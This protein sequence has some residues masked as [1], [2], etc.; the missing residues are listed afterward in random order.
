[1]ARQTNMMAILGIDMDLHWN[2]A[3]FMTF[4]LIESQREFSIGKTNF[5]FESQISYPPQKT[6]L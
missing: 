3:Q 2:Y 6:K 4:L 5:Q 1:M